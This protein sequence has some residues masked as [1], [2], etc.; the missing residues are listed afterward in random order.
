MVPDSVDR[1]QLNDKAEVTGIYYDAFDVLDTFDRIPVCV[2]YEVDG[3]RTEELPMTQ[4]GFHHATPIYEYLPGWSEDISSARSIDDLPGAARA[5]VREIEREIGV[6]AKDLAEISAE[7]TAGERGVNSS[8]PS[9]TMNHSGSTRGI[10]SSS[11]VPM[12]AR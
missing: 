12:R 3:V 9:S 6:S 4:T 1:Y 2:A 8:A 10:P 5:F 11:T 7:I